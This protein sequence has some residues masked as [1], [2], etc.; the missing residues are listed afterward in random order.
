MSRQTVVDGGGVSLEFFVLGEARSKVT[1]VN[2]DSALL[3]YTAAEA[4]RTTP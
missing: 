1:V 3:I 2:R 4:E